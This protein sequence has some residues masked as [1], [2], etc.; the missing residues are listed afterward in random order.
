LVALNQIELILIKLGGSKFR[1]HEFW[2]FR[3]SHE[4]T[5]PAKIRG[6]YGLSPQITCSWFEIRVWQ[7]AACTARQA[8][9]IGLHQWSIQL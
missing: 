8:S 6:V 1:R 4:T 5:M 9:T 2:G 7:L 3:K